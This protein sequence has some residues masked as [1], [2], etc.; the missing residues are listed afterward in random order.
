M[1]KIKKT[2]EKIFEEE[3]KKIEIDGE[4]I[5][6]IN[7]RTGGIEINGIME[8]LTWSLVKI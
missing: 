5:K 7:L 6:I 4:E 3:R 1:I 8:I 2:K